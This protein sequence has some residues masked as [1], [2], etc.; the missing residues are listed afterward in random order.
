MLAFL[1][2]AVVVAVA[3]GTL[4]TQR[5][6]NQVKQQY[7]Q[8]ALQYAEHAAEEVLEGFMFEAGHDLPALAEHLWTEKLGYVQIL[9]DGEVI[10]QK[11]RF[12]VNL[13]PLP[14]PSNAQVKEFKPN[15]ELTSYLDV[16]YPLEQASNT[17]L[18]FGHFI[19]P[20]VQSRLQEV[21]DS[22]VRIGFSLQ[23]LEH[24]LL[25][26]SLLLTGLSLGL[27]ALGILFGWILFRMILGPIERLSDTM[28]AFGAG[29]VSARVEVHS[30]DEI[31]ML[32]N[33]FNTMAQSIVYQRDAL[34]Q[35]NAE[36]EKANH[37]KS[38][39]LT[40][41][42]HEL[43]TPLH[44]VLGYASLLRDEVN[45]KLSKAGH[46]YT[47]AV[48]RSGQH[49]LA[50]I[51]NLIE[52]SRIE[53]GGEP[54]HPEQ[55][56]ASEVI[57]EVLE[58]Q[59]PLLEKKGL[60]LMVEVEPDLPLHTDKT[61][62]K[63]VLLNLIDNAIKYTDRG[64]IRV[65]AERRNRS[66]HFAIADTGIGIASEDHGTLFEPFIRAERTGRNGQGMGLGL[67]VVNRYVKLM[68][69]SLVFDSVLG[70]G[71][72]FWFA[73]PLAASTLPTPPLGGLHETA[74]R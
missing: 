28:R 5:L 63:Q 16:V 36:L 22:Y 71:S 55:F 27:M 69:G 64:Q 60:H 7:E 45:V 42:S 13:A 17:L 32:A 37:V 73:L 4:T 29:T 31:E 30:G 33:E 44:S 40:T 15:Q 67:T 23:A 34:R 2:F 47:N 39:F 74:S 59:R 52:I 18:K 20:Q 51:E 35:T 62:L 50:L 53:G 68:G 1:G 70:E 58:N 14:K 10:S 24:E 26:E 41:I 9:I 8:Y 25:Q 49:L 11:Q 38:D 72:H 12:A 66:V 21:G 54:L 19:T 56:N 65:L 61:K 57:A 43:R 46:K 6:K 3:F 48:L